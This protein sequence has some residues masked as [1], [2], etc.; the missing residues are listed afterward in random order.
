[1]DKLIINTPAPADSGAVIRAFIRNGFAVNR[2]TINK[3]L[4]IVEITRYC[5]VKVSNCD[6]AML[7]QSIYEIV[8]LLGIDNID[9]NSIDEDD[10]YSMATAQ[11]V[12]IQRVYDAVAPYIANCDKSARYADLAK[13]YR[14]VR[15]EQLAED[16]AF[17]IHFSGCKKRV[18]QIDYS[19]YDAV[20]LCKCLAQYGLKSHIA[21]G[22]LYIA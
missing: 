12:T 5:G 4:L 22:A 2:F 20:T 9:C 3:G 14:A 16:I 18:Y 15:A 17:K 19:Q 8:T 21:S 13:C 7:L 1:M 10:C 11:V 6:Y